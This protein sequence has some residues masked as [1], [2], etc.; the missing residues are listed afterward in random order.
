MV[1]DQPFESIDRAD[2]E[3]LIS[4]GVAEGKTIEYKGRLPDNSYKAKK[5]FLADVSSFSNAAGG[6]LLL[7]IEEEAGIATRIRGIPDI[8][9]DAEI[10][11]LENLLRDCVDPRIQGLGMR[12]ID[13]GSSTVLVIRVPHSW[14][15]PHAVRLKSHWRFCSRSSAGKY[16]LDV[17][18]LRGHFLLS[19]TRAERIRAFRAERLGKIVSGQSPLTLPEGPRTA[20]HIVPFGSLDPGVKLDLASLEQ[21]AWRFTPIGVGKVHSHRYNL[22]GL[23]TSAWG[24][25]STPRSYLQIFRNGSIEAAEA[26]L[27]RIGREDER[28]IHSGPYEHE[29]IQALSGFL[30]IQHRLGVEPPLYVMLSLLHVSGYVVKPA[31]SRVDPFRDRAKPIDR[32]DLL[33]PEITI[34]SFETHVARAMRPVFDAVWNASGWPRCLNYD[35]EGEWLGK[36]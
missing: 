7:G 21:D 12:A 3:A 15:Q 8:D 25:D 16:P 31:H 10:L 11:R 13:V 33:L 19:E 24:V 30:S 5:E 2:L 22:D 26:S 20:L 27:M 9:A 1:L 35:D 29:L 32:A 6:H 28:V 34:D 36:A 4:N 17:S 14:A 18:E 23:L